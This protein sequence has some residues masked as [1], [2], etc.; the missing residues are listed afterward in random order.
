MKFFIPFA[1][2]EAQGE[3]VLNA[4]SEFTGFPIPSPRI[5][6]LTYQHNGKEMI[7][8]VGDVVPGYYQEIGPVIAILYREGLFAICTRDR[9]VARGEPIYA[10]A[11]SVLSVLHFDPQ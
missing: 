3:R 8:T 10:N 9:G 7:A 11:Q 1:S 6:S 5:Y 2:D 4:V